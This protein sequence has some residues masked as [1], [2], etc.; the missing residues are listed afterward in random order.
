MLKTGGAIDY[1]LYTRETKGDWQLLRTERVEM[2]TPETGVR[3]LNTYPNP[4]GPETT[5]SIAV[6]NAQRVDI[7]VYDAAGRLVAKLVEGI[8]PVGTHT[9]QWDGRDFSGRRVSSG[10]YFLRLKGQKATDVQK[11][12]VVR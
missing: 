12:V 6:G 7:R 8:Y 5:V 4:L 9:V 2:K 3:I 11:F 10:V 1:T